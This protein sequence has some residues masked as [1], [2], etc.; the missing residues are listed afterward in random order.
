MSHPLSINAYPTIQGHRGE[1]IPDDSS[2]NFESPVNLICM[3]LECERKPEH[4]EGT[5]VY[6]WKTSLTQ[7]GPQPNR[8][9]TQESL[10]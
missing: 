5:H 7:E 6:K 4:S 2:H 9:Q 10:L 3:T 1:T 8:N